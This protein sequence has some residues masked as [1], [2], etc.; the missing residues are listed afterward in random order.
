[1]FFWNIFT[2]ICIR[3]RT[4]VN[5]KYILFL[6][7]FGLFLEKRREKI[8]KKRYFQFSIRFFYMPFVYFTRKIICQWISFLFLVLKNSLFEK[9]IVHLFNDKFITYYLFFIYLFIYS[10]PKGIKDIKFSWLWHYF[11][12]CKKNH[13][14][15]L[16]NRIK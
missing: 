14:K 4:F 16:H 6:K 3:R 7:L 1:M 13:L 15:F 12:F 9:L 5:D 11:V 10:F 2:L 8:F